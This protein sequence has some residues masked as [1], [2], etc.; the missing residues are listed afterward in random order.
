MINK[1]LNKPGHYSGSKRLDCSE[2]EEPDFDSEETL[3]KWLKSGKEIK[4]SRSLKRWKEKIS[5]TIDPEKIQIHM[6][7][8]SHIDCAWMWRF[9]QTRKKAQVTFKKAILHAKMFPETFCYALSQPLLLEW[10]QEDNKVLF[11]EIQKYVKAGNIELVGGSYVEPDCMMPSG[12]AMIRQRLYGLRFYHD[13][14]GVL[15]KIEWFL[16]S[17]GY[18]IGIPQIL[19]KSGAKYFWTT[20]LTWNLDTIFP[21]VNFF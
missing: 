1:F 6:V 9:E 8:Q 12:E 20:K 5:K 2:F 4:F 17:F 10:I 18:N 21:F 11:K 19:I 7:G 15:P 14:F 16:D 3:K 13:N